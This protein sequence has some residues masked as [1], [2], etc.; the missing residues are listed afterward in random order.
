MATEDERYRQS[1]QFRLWSFS[2]GQ[3][4]DLRSKTNSLAKQNIS[5]RLSSALP[6]PT[7]SATASANP[8]G[9]NTPAPEQASTATAPADVPMNVNERPALPDFLTPTEEEQLLRFYTVEALRAAE[10]CRLPTEIRATAA[11]FLRRFFLTHSIMTY[12]PTKMLKT[13][14]FFGAKAENSYPRVASFAENFPNTTGEEILAGEFLLCQGL[15]FAFDVRHPY[16]ALEG[17]I[18]QLR[19]LGDIDDSKITRAQTRGREVLK[20]SPLVTDAYF[21]YT[22][23]QIMLAALSIADHDLFER[24]VELIFAKAGGDLN[25]N[26]AEAMAQVVK[27]KT[28]STVLACK[29]MLMQEPPERLSD[30]YGTPEATSIMKP[31]IKKLKKCRDP[32]RFDLIALHKKRLEFRETDAKPAKGPM[33]DGAV[34]GGGLNSGSK[35]DADHDV[36]RRKVAAD[37]PFGPPL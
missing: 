20:F 8:S 6:L 25:S 13:C 19:S 22:P 37:D 27:A 33:D 7:A 3:L 24:M 1:T 5:E 31:L 9:S 2:P 15:R 12:P 21:H 4:A 23:S 30:F 16:R 10:F 18:M 36:K 28:I 35:A 17:A 11:I 29:E 34:F 32:D 26:Q 14:L